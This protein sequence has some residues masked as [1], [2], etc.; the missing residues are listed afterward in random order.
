MLLTGGVLCSYA[1]Q[2]IFVCTVLLGTVLCDTHVHNCV[3]QPIMVT[4]CYGNEMW[5]RYIHVSTRL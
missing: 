1:V 3:G 5:C 4:S 2:R